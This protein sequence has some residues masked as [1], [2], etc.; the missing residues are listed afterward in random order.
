LPGSRRQSWGSVRA[1][2]SGRY[3][4]RYFDP[5]TRSRISAPQTFATKRS[6]DRWLAA[7]RTGIDAGTAVDDQAGKQPLGEWWPS[8]WRSLQSRKRTTQVNYST[9]WRLRIEPRFGS[10]PVR[11]IKPTH[12]DDWISDM[13]ESGVSATKVIEAV[14]VL[15]RL[16]DRAVRDKAIQAN[17]CV[18]R[19]VS[20]PRRPQVERPVLTPAE[21]DRLAS[22]MTHER[23]RVL[24]RILA[25][26]GVRIGEA[27]ALRWTDVDLERGLLAIRQSVEDSTG[28]LIVGPTKTYATRT[29]TLPQFLMADLLGIRAAITQHERSHLVFPNQSGSYLRYGNWRRDCW[30]P[31]VKR[32]GVVALPHDLRATCASLLIDAG[33][34]VKDV[35]AYFGHQDELTTLRIYA[36]VRPHRSADIAAKLDALVAETT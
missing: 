12:V 31:A 29:L 24:V 4:A 19:Q 33:A 26:A 25:Y 5:D 3:Q 28:P 34:S 35:Q 13:I 7:K 2:P 15:R 27:F 11:R 20:L 1:L 10:T 14:G 21:V 22:A 8:Y 9:A 36:R 17:P 6:A 18:L 16:L 30:N 32:S 23:D